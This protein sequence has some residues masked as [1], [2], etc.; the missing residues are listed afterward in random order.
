M[1]AHVHAVTPSDTVN[2][3]QPSAALYVG[4]TGGDVVVIGASTDAAVT[5]EAVPSGTWLWIRATRVL[6]TG[7]TATNILSHWGR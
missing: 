1:F 4:G 6:A 5:Y 7:T 3:P 2:L